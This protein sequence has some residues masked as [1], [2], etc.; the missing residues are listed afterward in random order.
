MRRSIVFKLFLLTAALCMSVIASLFVF[1]T[2]FFKQFYVHQKTGSVQAALGAASQADWIHAGDAQT[3]YRNE[4]QFYQKYNTWIA[5]LDAEGNLKVADDFEM[6]VRLENSVDAPAL[7]GQSITVPLYTVMNVE[8]L[9]EDNPLQP[10]TI[11]KPGEHIAIEGVI[12]DNRPYPQRIGRDVSN[13]REENRL[14]N[15]QL[16]RKEYEALSRLSATDY[17]ERYPSFLAYGTVTQVRTPEGSDE[18]RYTNHLFLERV[19]AFQADLLYGDFSGKTDT[20]ADYEEN[21][22]PYKIFVK[23]L[24]DRTGNAEYL[25]AMTS[26]QP[27]NEAAGVMRHYY[28]YI[29]LGT[30]LLVLLAAFYYSRRIARPLLRLNEATQRMAGLDFSARIPVSTEDEI[31][32]LS[33]NINGLSGLLYDHIIRLEQDIEQEKRLEQTRKEFISG[34]SHELKTP[35]SVIESCLYI[36]KD[37]PD[38][39]KREYY[40]SAMEDEVKRMNL[41]IADMLELARYESGTYRMEMSTFRIDAVLERVCAKLAGE[42]ADKRLKLHTRFAPVEV[43]ANPLRIEQVIVNFLTNAIRYTPEGENVFVE[44]DEEQETVKVGIENKGAHIPDDQL[45]K[46][47]DR[48]YRG[49]RSRHR[50]TGGTGLGLAIS[51]QILELHGALYGAMNTDDGVRFFFELNKSKEA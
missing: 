9:S 17:R 44:A 47:W 49:E 12:I 16:V 13:L 10:F 30:L 40:F 39:Q 34:V 19:K 1:Q 46:I 15:E 7:S 5:A 35:L 18:S 4:Q 6:E 41:L 26:L 11:V 28:G 29:A 33:R 27:V 21:N 20:I 14:E 42:F 23:R 36:L 50:S 8:D 25:I 3:A 48:F 51:K 32:S 31:G 24:T 37:K 22:V 45:E 43:V 2:V 38:S